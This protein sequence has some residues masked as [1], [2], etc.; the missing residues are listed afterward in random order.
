MFESMLEG[1]A[2]QQ[3]S[4]GLQSITIE[5]RRQF[6]KRFADFCGAYPWRWEPR[7]LEDFTSRARSGTAPLS[8]STLRGY[9][10]DIRLFCDFITDARY[11][12]QAECVSRFG[13]PPQQICHDWNTTAHLLEAEG[14]PGRR[15]LTFDELEKFFEAADERVESIVRAGKKGALSAL[16]DAQMFKTI[17]AFGLRRSECIGLDVADLR[18]N[19]SA[20]Q[21][22]PF[23]ALYVRHGKGTR[24]TGPKRRTVL[25]LPEFDWIIDGLSQWVER[26]RPRMLSDWDTNVLWPTERRTRVS[27]RYLNVRFVDLRE[28]AGLPSE[29]T[30]H[31]LR[32]TYVTNLI[33]WGYSEKF[34]QDQVGHAYA[35]TTAIYTSVGDDFKN[36]VLT[37]ALRRTKGGGNAD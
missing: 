18:S 31:A 6:I 23:G 29:L 25:T 1:W 27:P 34:V 16:R 12:W 5:R 10:I 26:G 21:F 24:G 19:P 22:G 4:R 8:R 15:A 13:S 14:A 11:G 36:R 7:D 3:A 32:H 9:Q 33:E 30:P 20:P 17:Y 35:S 37:E 28:Q 2:D